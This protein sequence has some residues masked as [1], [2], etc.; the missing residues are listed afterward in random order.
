[1]CFKGML[2]RQER[3]ERQSEGKVQCVTKDMSWIHTSNIV[4]TWYVCWPAEAAGQPQ[5]VW[6][7]GL[8]LIGA[9]RLGGTQLL[10]NRR[11][12]N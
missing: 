12:Q 3:E 10:G 4:S 6:I 9:A 11:K 1:M 2:W 7:C 5:E 8:F